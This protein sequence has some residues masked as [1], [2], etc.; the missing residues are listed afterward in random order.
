MNLLVKTVPRKYPRA[1]AAGNEVSR[2][3][4][5]PSRPGPRSSR[6]GSLLNGTPART[7][8]LQKDE[9]VF[10]LGRRARPGA[11]LSP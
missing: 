4:E 10:P 11:S 5:V 8:G 7:T 3:H 2:R 1:A 9:L 6:C